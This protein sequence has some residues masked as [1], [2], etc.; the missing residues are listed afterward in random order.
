MGK[1]LKVIGT[2]FIKLWTWIKETAWVQ[3]LLI[4][5]IIFAIIFSIP[6]I[7]SWVQ[8]W[9]FGSDS[10]TFLKNNQL[11]LEGITDTTSEGEAYDFF[12]AFDEAQSQWTEGNKS[13]AQETMR[14]YVGDSNKMILFFVNENDDAQTV[15]EAANYL[16]NESW[17]RVTA[18]SASAPAFRYNSIFADEVVEV[19]SND[20]TYADHTPFDFLF[21]LPQYSDFVNQA[22]SIA[23]TSPYY[24]NRVAKGEDISSIESSAD[25]LPDPSNYTSAIPYYVIIDLTESNNTNYLITNVFFSF[26]GDDKYARA[27]FLAHAWTNTEEF[28]ITRN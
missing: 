8:S 12:D 15:N 27:D 14:N 21:N 22:A 24:R 6:S 18:I 3:P 9:N 16:V 7:T 10:Y 20:K 2:P 25:K 11:S 4:V 28:A 23:T 17:N 19:D 26:E 13:A 1:F 5:G